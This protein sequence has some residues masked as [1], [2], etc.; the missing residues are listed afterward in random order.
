MIPACRMPPPNNFRARRASAIKA[1]VPTSTEPSPQAF[2]EA[3]ADRIKM[4]RPVGFADSCGRHRIPQPGPV[5]MPPQ[6]ILRR[7]LA[8]LRD[9]VDRLDRAATAIVR[10]L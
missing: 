6:I 5:E 4:R 9:H 8:N 2:A 7:P 10:V 3:D 1:F